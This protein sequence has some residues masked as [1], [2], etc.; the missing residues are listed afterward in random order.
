[1]KK[2]LSNLLSTIGGKCLYAYQ[3]VFGM[4]EKDLRDLFSYYFNSAIERTLEVWQG[5]HQ[6]RKLYDSVGEVYELLRNDFTL[7]RSAKKSVQYKYSF[8]LD[9]EYLSSIIDIHD[10][11]YRTD[12][13]ELNE[14][15][16]FRFTI[17]EGFGNYFKGHLSKF[18]NKKELSM[19][20]ELGLKGI[21]G[22]YCQALKSNPEL[23]KLK[24]LFGIDYDII[25]EE[26]CNRAIEDFSEL[27]SSFFC[28]KN[29]R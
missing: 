6:E 26:E 13:N 12:K 4:S 25:I 5:K 16:R 29:R 19:L 15:Y 28:T 14:E 27:L 18:V 10:G 21:I 1:M 20:D 8:L 3:K 9:E 7:Y 22:A 24:T 17:R 2:K 11:K 23:L